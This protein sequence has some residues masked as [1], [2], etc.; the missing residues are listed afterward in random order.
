MPLKCEPEKKSPYACNHFAVLQIGPNTKR[1]EIPAVEQ[2]LKQRLAHGDKVY[3]A[4]GHEVDEHQIGKAKAQL[5]EPRPYAEELLLIH[6]QPPRESSKQIKA[7]VDN[8]RNQ[9]SLPPCRHPIPLSHP[10]AGFWFAQT[11]EPDAVPRPSWE[12]LG[13]PRA[14]SPDDMA[15]DIVFDS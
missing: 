5:M 3:C 7:L 14:G 13:L 8:L 4:C 9:A 11:P 2:K 1:I 6:P 15:L 12:H 10:A